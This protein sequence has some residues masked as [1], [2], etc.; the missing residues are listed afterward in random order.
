[1][2]CCSPSPCRADPSALR[3]LLVGNVPQILPPS[4]PVQ[5]YLPGDDVEGVILLLELHPSWGSIRWLVR[6]FGLPRLHSVYLPEEVPLPV[7]DLPASSRLS[8]SSISDG[9]T[10]SAGISHPFASRSTC[11]FRCGSSGQG[12]ASA[13]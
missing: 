8:N 6:G 1:M 3:S 9:W 2:S 10:S 12:C 5:A 11:G 13:A 7:R 4:L